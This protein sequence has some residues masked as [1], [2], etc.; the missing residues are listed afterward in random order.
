M[1]T[2]MNLR[3]IAL[4]LTNKN[5]EYETAHSRVVRM[6][7]LDT[8]ETSLNTYLDMIYNDPAEWLAL[9]T[10][11]NT[12]P[13]SAIFYLLERCPEVKNV[14]GAERC[15]MVANAV[16]GEWKTIRKQNKLAAASAISNNTPA[17][18]DVG[19]GGNECHS[20]EHNNDDHSAACKQNAK[21]LEYIDVLHKMIYSLS[22]DSDIKLKKTIE[23]CLP[24]MAAGYGVH[25]STS[26]NEWYFVGYSDET[27]TVPTSSS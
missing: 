16:R 3:D 4:I 24:A 23:V 1:T 11:D 19:G 7:G 9:C 12:K 22:A 25:T 27:V 6:L 8:D 15:S 14:I 5:R 18:N 2:T 20:N 13:K 10:P 21:L 26:H 17:N